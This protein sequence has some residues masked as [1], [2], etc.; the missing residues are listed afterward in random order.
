MVDTTFTTI[1]QAPLEC[2]SCVEGVTQALSSVKGIENV[3]IDLKS[4][5]IAVTGHVPP[6]EIVKSLQNIG[7]DAIV[8][9]SGKPDSAAVCILETFNP[10]DL[11]NPVKGLARI[12]EIA[13]KQI[14]VD[15]TINGV[16]KGVY[17]PLIRSSGDLSHGAISTGSIFHKLAPLGIFK[18]CQTNQNLKISV[19][20]E[21]FAGQSFLQ[22]ELSVKD[23]IGRSMV[24]SRDENHVDQSSLCGVIARSAGAWENDKMVCSCS[25]KNVWQERHDAVRKGITN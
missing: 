17:Y 1:F 24:L 3:D 16:E 21:L 18:P 10:A 20:K 7:K 15:L 12:V 5:R 13:N 11:H 25:G 6:S 14:V 19:S 2:D 23:L 22:A 4:Q 8:R 9:G